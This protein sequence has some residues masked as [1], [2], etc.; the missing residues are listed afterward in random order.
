MGDIE[1][2]PFSTGD[3]AG[4]I[5]VIPPIQQE[6]FGVALTAADQPDLVAIPGFYQS[7]SF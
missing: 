4:V 3:I 5:G 7:R 2:R 1:I 6:E